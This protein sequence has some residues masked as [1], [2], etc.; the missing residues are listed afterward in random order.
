ENQTLTRELPRLLRRPRP[1][2]QEGG[3]G[4]EGADREQEGGAFE[5][6]VLRVHGPAVRPEVQAARQGGPEADGQAAVRDELARQRR[7]R[8]R[9]G[10]TRWAGRCTLPRPPLLP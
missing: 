4:N 9:Q 6:D 7:D 3:A 5:Q 2:A 10:L 1:L 8:Q